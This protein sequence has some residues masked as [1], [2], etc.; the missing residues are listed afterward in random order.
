M[1]MYYNF[2]FSLKYSLRLLGKTDLYRCTYAREDHRVINCSDLS[3]T[4]GV[5]RT[6][7]FQSLNQDS[8]WQIRMAWLL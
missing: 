7:D 4:E 2:A 6:G 8:L 5:P 1:Y 3:Q